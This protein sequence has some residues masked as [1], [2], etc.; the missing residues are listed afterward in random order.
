MNQLELGVQMC[1]SAL[2][3]GLERAMWSAWC[4]LVSV[5]QC[6]QERTSDCLQ[7][8]FG[9]EQSEQSSW[10]EDHKSHCVLLLLGTSLLSPP[11]TPVPSLSSSLAASAGV[12][13]QITPQLA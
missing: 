13:P 5:L 6:V 1:T 10:S 3:H 11:R 7:L 9:A 4:I 12:W 2:L 8:C